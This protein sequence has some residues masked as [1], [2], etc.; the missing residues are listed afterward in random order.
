MNMHIII[1]FYK[2]QTI[3]NL[4]NKF[5]NIFINYNLRKSNI[6]IKTLSTKVIRK[7]THLSI[8]D[9]Y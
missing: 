7:K 6:I 5:I 9:I 2:F 3:Q 8:S 1:P 4:I